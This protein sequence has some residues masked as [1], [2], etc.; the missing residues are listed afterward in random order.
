MRRVVGRLS[1]A[2][3]VAGACVPSSESGL[4]AVPGA[5]AVVMA[6]W[7]PRDDGAQA[8]LAASAS[9]AITVGWARGDEARIYVFDRDLGALGLREGP[10]ALAPDSRVRATNPP[11]LAAFHRDADG[12]LHPLDPPSDGLRLPAIDL[13]ATLAAGRCLEQGSLVSEVCGATVALGRA[14]V[15][16]PAWPLFPECP[17]GWSREA[18]A[19]DRGATLGPATVDV[20]AP[21]AWADCAAPSMQAA[22][23]VG[24]GPIGACAAGE[25]ADALPAD[26]TFVR[27]GAV[28]GDG[29][30]AHPFGAIAQA[31]AARARTI[32][33]ARG[34]YA[35]A[36]ALTGEVDVIGPC[37]AETALED[38]VRLTAFRGALRGLQ[39]SS[40]GEAL[41]VLGPSTVSAREVWLDGGGEAAALVVFD[42]TVTLERARVDGATRA[43]RASIAARA[44]QLDGDIGTSSSSVA[45][46]DVTLVPG[47]SAASLDR[48]R[49][50]MEASR[51]GATVVVD[52]GVADVRRSH[53]APMRPESQ[54]DGLVGH[55]SRA[56]VSATVFRIEDRERAGPP[57]I[58]V[59]LSLDHGQ[60]TVADVVCAGP[61]LTA[62][63]A[64]V[65]CAGF[66]SGGPGER[67]QVR[68]LL[69]SGGGHYAQLGI[70]GL[71]DA[72]DVRA[73]GGAGTAV[74]V[75]G[76]RVSLRRLE[77]GGVSTGIQATGADAADGLELVLRDLAVADAAA[78]ALALREGD[79][80][81]VTR[82]DVRR[83]WIGGGRG[84]A[85][86]ISV[87]AGGTS[88]PTAGLA[89]DAVLREVMVESGH[90][91]AL[92]MSLDLALDLRSFALSSA[93]PA[94]AYRVGH[95]RNLRRHALS[96]GVLRAPMVAIDTVGTG[97]EIES[98]LDHV[99]V[100]A[101]RVW[102]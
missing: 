100:D 17:A 32:A 88:D 76:G 25:F 34:R 30:R 8:L 72:E 58:D 45:L 39:V 36:V 71:V 5:R 90:S 38:G 81:H 101:P 63:D 14:A 29:S 43:R 75:I 89:L 51:V 50:T 11:P 7:P 44:A 94:V 13:E 46:D 66:A 67:H 74:G 19:I 79:L 62:T 9:V 77:L 53:W 40:S 84:R 95:R 48:S 80:A 10:L 15:T 70:V 85:A 86:A 68:R 64:T 49:L 87:R 92:E 52:H 82:A 35:E 96:R 54:P 73:Y 21:P 61:T 27:A 41:V 42:S 65:G 24:C 97:E 37:A 78:E 83:V 47:A 57:R 99:R 69:I 33:L 20:C 18:L 4:P 59:M 102:R 2:A 91:A 6:W 60:S 93:G 3:L 23:D 55:F 56:A 22:R 28:G 98:L 31:V 26:A 16:A 1:A 12:E